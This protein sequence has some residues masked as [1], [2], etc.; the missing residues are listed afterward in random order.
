MNTTTYQYSIAS[1]AM[2]AWLTVKGV[3][4]SATEAWAGMPLESKIGI[5]LGFGTFALNW[6]YKRRRDRREEAA[7]RAARLQAVLPPAGAGDDD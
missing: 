2:S 5:A 1:Y 3:C 4:T 6:Y 7:F